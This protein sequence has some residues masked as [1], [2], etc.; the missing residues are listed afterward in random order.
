[1]PFIIPNAIDTT[2]SN[3][4]NALDQ[5]EPDALDFQILGNRASGVISGCEVTPQTVSNYTVAVGSGYVA[6]NGTVY[7]VS[8]NPSLTLPN[9][10]VT[11]RFDVVVARLTSGTIN[12]TVVKGPESGT[13]P[14]FP[15][16]PSRMTT[17][18][19]VPTDT[20]ID[21]DTD[22]VLATI[23]RS[24]ASTITSAF[25][26]DK[27]VNVP[28]TTSL[29]GDIEP[30][31][32]LGQD[33][34]FYYKS[35]VSGP[36]G[37]FVKVDGT[38]TRL[39][40]ALPTAEGGV[41]IGTVITWVSTTALPDSTKWVECNGAELSRTS[42]SDLFSVIGTAYGAPTVNT[43]R[44]PNFAGFFLSGLGTG[45][46]IG[47]AYGATNNQ[48][49]LT[50]SQLPSHNHGVGSLA[51]NSLGTH[52]HYTTGSAGNYVAG[53]MLRS[54]LANESTGSVTVASS[55]SGITLGIGYTGEAGSHRHTMSGSTADTGSGSAVTIEPRNYGVKYYIKYA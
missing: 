4:Y 18:V 14:T 26:V 55:T 46:V 1:M 22:V 21:P 23:Y 48:V 36:A 27:R 11:A 30:P 2:G 5:A 34:D 37:I 43:F 6:V 38:W 52:D 24:G 39:G 49:T 42:Y 45:R 31:S 28:M 25:I 54:S 7:T 33:G 44:V 10:P 50:T 35:S 13:N 8:T 53:I 29:K 47:T 51:M 9:A 40:L 41:P 19:G 12:I 15:P 32:L 16:T 20:W 17:T 3:R